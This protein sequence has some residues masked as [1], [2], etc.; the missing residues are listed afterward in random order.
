[1]K[2]SITVQIRT[3]ATFLFVQF[4]NTLLASFSFDWEESD[5]FSL[6]FAAELPRRG[7]LSAPCLARPPASTG[8]S[9]LASTGMYE[10]RI[11]RIGATMFRI[12]ELALAMPF[13][14]LLTWTTT[15]WAENTSQ[16]RSLQGCK[17][18]PVP[19]LFTHL[20]HRKSFCRTPHFAL[21]FGHRGGQNVLRHAICDAKI[22][23]TRSLL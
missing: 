13:W 6:L 14:Q 10:S 11:G 20:Q 21:H 22:V 16:K 15:H 23:L 9:A 5:H 18:V 1:M 2:L 19:V 17:N 4:C 12:A 8:C 7:T 3:W